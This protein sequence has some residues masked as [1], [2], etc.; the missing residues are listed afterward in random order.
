[1]SMLGIGAFLYPFLS[2]LSTEG[3]NTSHLPRIK[4]GDIKNNEIKYIITSTSSKE[5]K[6][7][8]ST[9]YTP[10]SSWLVIRN[11]LGEFYVYRV[12][13]W[14][15]K[16]LMPRVYWSQFE[17]VCKKLEP[18]LKNGKITKESKILCKDSDVNSY[19]QNIWKWTLEGKN[20]SG[21]IPDMLVIPFKI[22]L[23]ELVLLKS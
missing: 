22:E 18:E 13:T 17:G 11:D 23:N 12:P 15:E 8:G 21:Q 14:E 9:V 2:S 20:I 6:H 3:I 16:V 7:N 4:I 10:G 1:M 19:Q 5:E